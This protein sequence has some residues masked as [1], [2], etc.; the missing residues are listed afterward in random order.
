MKFVRDIIAEKK[1]E[2]SDHESAKRREDVISLAGQSADRQGD[3]SST[4]ALYPNDDRA[5]QE[6]PGISDDN[7][8]RGDP[9]AAAPLAGTMFDT[10]A[11][12]IGEDPAEAALADPYDGG[13]DH[14][15]DTDSLSDPAEEDGQSTLKLSDNL[16]QKL[17][18]DA[19][20]PEDVNTA[21]AKNDPEARIRR[22][23]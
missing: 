3:L 5:E 7:L 19:H 13:T 14:L 8:F 20:E 16:W 4:G 12:D 1:R 10:P 6:A 23:G 21:F 11:E 22:P 15:Q 17:G 2:T 9:H 18:N